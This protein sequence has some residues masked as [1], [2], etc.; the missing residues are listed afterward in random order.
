[1]ITIG[2]GSSLTFASG[3]NYIFSISDAN[4]T[5]GVGYSTVDLGGGTLAIQ[6]TGD[7]FNINLYSFDPSTNLAGMAN[8]F[9]P[10]LPY[11]WTL[12]SAASITGFDSSDFAFNLTNFQ[13]PIGA[14]SFFVSQ[15]GGDLMLNFT[16]VPEPSTWALMASGLFA[17]GAAVR[18][19]RR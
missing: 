5:P 12:V 11:S 9:N 4:G 17:L 13:N 2:G 14:G 3:G 10:A 16:P 18:R 19:R 8:N 1:M 7:P 15:S 6:F